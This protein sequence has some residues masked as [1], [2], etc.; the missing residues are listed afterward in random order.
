MK[1]VSLKTIL[2]SASGFIRSGLGN[3]FSFRRSWYVLLPLLAAFFILALAFDVFVFSVYGVSWKDTI[4]RPEIRVT[5]IR[6]ELFSK[7]LSKINDRDIRFSETLEK[8]LLI[9]DPFR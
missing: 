4:R 2:N 6:E 7:L 9:S 1:P 8:D 3:I 5:P